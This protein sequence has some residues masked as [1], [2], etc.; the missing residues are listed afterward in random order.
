[1]CIQLTDE[2]KNTA[3]EIAIRRVNNGMFNR[4]GLTREERID[5]A[6]KG[7]LGEVAFE[8]LLNNN[9]VEYRTDIHTCDE[10]DHGDFFINNCSI[11]V[12]IAKTYKTPMPRW[13][14]GVPIGQNPELKDYTII[15]WWN[16]TQNQIHFY[17]SIRGENLE[18]RPVV[19][20]NTFTGARYLTNNIE[21]TWGELD[22]N[23]DG[24]LGNIQL[25]H[26]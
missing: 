20:F 1:M 15:G 9:G 13:M 14:F 23:F 18:G 8:Q 4:F 6:Y 7:A 2:L 3:R 17:G 22:Q 12:K 24:L 11:D 19:N 26:N 5:N 21:I 10:P 16:P 25:D